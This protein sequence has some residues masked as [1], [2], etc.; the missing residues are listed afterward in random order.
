MWIIAFS[1]EWEFWYSA[2]DNSMQE[3]VLK[4]IKEIKSGERMYEHLKN[5][6]PYFK[7]EFNN[8]RFRICF[9]ETSETNTRMLFFVGD[10]K[11]YEKWLG[12]G[13]C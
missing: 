6:L 8:Q 5:G 9:T 3:I 4:K 10:H 2:L 11:N 12:Y 7:A 13:G 1:P